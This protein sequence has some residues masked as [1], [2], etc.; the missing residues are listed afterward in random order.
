MPGVPIGVLFLIA[1]VF[2]DPGQESNRSRRFG[3]DA[4]GPVDPSYIRLANETGGQ[5]MFLQPSEIAQSG[6]FMRESSGQNHVTLLWAS[7]QLQGATREFRIPV[8]STIDRL[9]FVA[10]HDTKGLAFQRYY[11]HLFHAESVEIDQ[12]ERYETVK[13][14]ETTPLMFIIR[15]VGPAATF[16]IVAADGFR[17]V[18][19]VEPQEIAVASGESKTVK[20]E[21]TVPPDTPE[22]KGVDVSVVA[23]STVPRA[24]SN[25]AVVH[26]SVSKTSP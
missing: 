10:S 25:S 24:T 21:I 13:P 12:S 1:A 23:S 4:C 11:S 8:D 6:H 7:A 2:S 16:H 19:R 17:F 18:S 5:P 15:N 14:G 3:P 9:T 22:G 26:L 20:V